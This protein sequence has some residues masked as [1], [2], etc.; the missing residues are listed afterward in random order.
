[1]KQIP[2]FEHSTEVL[3]DTTILRDVVDDLTMKLRKAQMDFPEKST[4]VRSA[5]MSRSGAAN[6]LDS[7]GMFERIVPVTIVGSTKGNTARVYYKP[8]LT[9]LPRPIRKAIVPH[10][11]KKFCYFDFKAAEY[12]W[13]CL[14]ANDVKQVQ[15]YMRGEDI[16]SVFNDYFPEFLT[17]AQKKV[18][19]IGN[20]YGLTKFTAAARMGTLEQVA[21]QVLAL[22]NR[23]QVQQNQLK[24][25]IIA[26]VRR[27]GVYFTKDLRTGEEFAVSPVQG[28]VKEDLATST[29]TQ[30]GLALET[31]RVMV[32]IAERFNGTILSVFDSLL[33]EVD[34][35]ETADNLTK[36][37][38]GLIKPFRANIGLGA[39]FQEAYENAQ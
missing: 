9:S 16:Y 21:E 25:E 3:I 7:C 26:R 4:E 29:F 39:S 33:F 20:M 5:K 8:S 37:I 1:M 17:R 15:A 32:E 27:E 30:S 2:S 19:L 18:C 24:R 12:F 23:A 34:E 35:N 14:M 11:G 31:R 22:V 38:E 6:L 28:W 36:I 10:Q 13:N